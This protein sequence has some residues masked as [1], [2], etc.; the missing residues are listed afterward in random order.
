MANVNGAAAQEGQSTDS[1]IKDSPST[2]AE[3]FIDGVP[4]TTGYQHNVP[5]SVPL[6]FVTK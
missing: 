1:R 4:S 6:G 2:Q 5:P 3:Y